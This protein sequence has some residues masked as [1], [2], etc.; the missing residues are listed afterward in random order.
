MAPQR[1]IGVVGLGYVGL[2]M[3]VAFS[4]KGHVVA[5]DAS[6][7]RIR[8]LQLNL[9]HN[10]EVPSDAINSGDILYTS[11]PRDLAPVDFYIVSVPTPLDA[12]KRPDLHMLVSASTMIGSML[13][14][15]DIVVYESS[16]YP[17]ATEEVCVPLL[18][19]H[20]S[21]K[22]RHD[23]NVGF[24]PERINPSDKEHVFD[25]IIK[26]VS[27]SDEKTL[28]IIASVYESVVKPG[29]YRVSSMRTAEATKLLENTQRDVNIALMNDYAMLLHRLDIDTQEVIAAMKTKWN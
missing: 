19:A 21:L 12:N 13:K 25:K 11:D 27:G 4:Q 22:Y 24:S 1:K 5:F 10:E 8:E 9:D 26:I 16:V 14:P 15:G 2:T 7:E 28:E 17:G 18:E 6:R 3:A 29:V 20:S 23:F